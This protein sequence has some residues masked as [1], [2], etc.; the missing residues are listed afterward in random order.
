MFLQSIAVAAT[1]MSSQI[2]WRTAHQ[3]V[4]MILHYKLKFTTVNLISATPH[5]DVLA[6]NAGVDVVHLSKGQDDFSY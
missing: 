5:V 6:S 4:G 3:E 1:E 2:R